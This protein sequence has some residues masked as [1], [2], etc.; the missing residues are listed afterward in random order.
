MIRN[1]RLYIF[2]SYPSE[3][4]TR[5]VLRNTRNLLYRFVGKILRY[6][7]IHY[8]GTVCGVEVTTL[9]SFEN[10]ADDWG[11]VNPVGR[12]AEHLNME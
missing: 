3:R 4:I 11:K 2:P 8:R 5:K 7:P 1:R 12:C 6:H 9:Q 10:T